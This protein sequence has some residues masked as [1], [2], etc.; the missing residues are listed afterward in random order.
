[1]AAS[2][3]AAEL[4]KTAA[5]R[6]GSLIRTFLEETGLLKTST[7]TI[8]A[9]GVSIGAAKLEA[10]EV[11]PAEAAITANKA[12][13]A[14][15]DIPIVGPVL[16]EIAF[17]EAMERGL[18]SLSVASAAGGFDI[19]AGINPM[20]QLHQREMVLPAEHADTIRGL[21]GGGGDVH[22]HVHATDADSVRRLFRD[23][24]R[25]MAEVLSQQ[26]RNFVKP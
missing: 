4:S 14:V 3:A 20:T 21:K 22:L 17:D 9:A 12:A 18:S 5:T 15:A 19:P 26:M 10:S 13:S 11:I 2:W 16:A 25:I 7:A 1:M 24:G 8:G 23:N 6:S